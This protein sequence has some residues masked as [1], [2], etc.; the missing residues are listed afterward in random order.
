MYLENILRV[1]LS[2]FHVSVESLKNIFWVTSTLYK[3]Y[4]AKNKA[5]ERENPSNEITTAILELL[6]D[7]LRGKSRVP[8]STLASIIEVSEIVSGPNKVLI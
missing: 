4:N 8:S 3:R 5:G 2:R 7:G 6:S 1:A